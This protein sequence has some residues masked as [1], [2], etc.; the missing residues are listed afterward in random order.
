N[1]LVLAGIFSFIVSLVAVLNMT[2]SGTAIDFYRILNLERVDSLKNLGIGVDEANKAIFGLVS[3][4]LGW[5]LMW[6]YYHM[7]YDQAQRHNGREMDR[8]LL[9]YLANISNRFN[10]IH[11]HAT[12]AVVGDA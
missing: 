5:L 4:A 3:C 6:M 1:V 7:A 10:R 8:L 11:A 2:V 9:G 12:Q